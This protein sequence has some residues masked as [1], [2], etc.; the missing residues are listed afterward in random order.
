M[1]LISHTDSHIQRT[2]NRISRILSKLASPINLSL[3]LIYVLVFQAV[4]FPGALA[5]THATQPAV[6]TAPPP[7]SVEAVAVRHAPVVN[8]GRIEGS[9]R[10]LLGENVTINSGGT[11]TGDL[12]V[13]GTPT[14]KLNGSP[15]YGGTIN[16]TG[17]TQPTGYLVT[18]NGGATLGRLVK[19]TD[20]ITLD[21]VAAPP[22]AQ[23]T[24]NVSINSAGQS[25]GDF[26]TLRD[27]TLNANAGLVS[28][29]PGTY[30][31]FTG[32]GG[33]FVFGIAGSTQ[34]TVYNLNQLTLN[35]GSDLRVVGPIVLT[36]GS[37]VTGNGGTFGSAANPTWL[38]LKLAT[39]ILT[40]NS[41]SSLYGIV[42]VPNGTVTLNSG[43][44]Q[45]SL[46]CDRLTINANSQLIGLASVPGTLQSINPTRGMQGQT[47]SVTLTGNNTHWVS[48]QT[49]ASFGGEVSVG[50]A[51]AGS[52]GPVTVLSQTTATADLTI[53][54]TASLSPRTVRVVTPLGGGNSEDISLT[55]A[56]I[57]TAVTPPGAATTNVSTIAGSDSQPGFADGPAAQ[58]RFRNLAGIATSADDTI[59]VAD[60]GNHRIRVVRRQPG[61]GTP[62]WTVQ[63]LAGDGTAG[64]RDGPGAQA[65]FNDPQSVAVDAGGDVYVADTG[66]HRIRR[67]APDGVV[68]TVAGDGVAGYQNGAGAQARFN[69]PRSLALDPQGNVYVADTG[70]SAVRFINSSGQVQTVAG[71][72]TIGMNDSPNAHFNG[73]AGIAVEGTSVFIYL[74]D[75]GNHRIRRLD[76][77]GTVI[78]LTGA[79][80]GFADGQASAA[81]FADPSGLAVDGSGRI[82]VAD[83]TNSLV[84]MVSPDLVINGSP[85]AVA[86]LAGT[87]ERGLLNGAGS[88]SRFNAPRGVA[89]TLSSAIIVSDTG[90]NVLR[91]IGIPPII[92]SF[93]PLSA[94]I[95]ATITIYGENFDGSAPGG[96]IVKFTRAATAGGGQTTAQVSAGSR[97]Q[98]SVVVPP[99]AATGP[100][101]VATTDGTAVSP[102]DFVVNSSLPPAITD[103]HP[104]RGQVGAIVT[105]IGTALQSNTGNTTVTF[106]G[107]DNLRLPALIN[108]VSATEVRTTVPNGAVTG[109]IELT[110]A[111]GVALTSQD[112]IVDE[113]QDFQV[114]AAPASATVLQ[115]G[116]ATFIVYVTS[117][118]T[119]FSQLAQLSAAGLP[120]A[121]TATFRPP[122]ITAGGKTTLSVNLADTNLSPGSYS[123]TINASAHIDGHEVVR[124]VNVNLSVMAA[125]GQ[126][127][128]AGRVLSSEDD[129]IIGA[130]A[131][132]DGHSATTDASGSFLLFGIGDGPNRP[133]MVD[134][135]T[136]NAPNRSYPVIIE[137][138]D[139]IA[140]HANVVPY[141]FYLPAIDTQYEVDVV[142]GQNTAVTNPRV[143]GLA[144]TIPAGANLRNR[145]GS[146]VV[147][148]SI[149]P[150]AIDRTP[151][152]LPSDVRTGMVYTSQPGGALTDVP[153]PVVYPNLTGIDPG[154]E[155]PLYAFNHDTVEWYVYGYGLV[156]QDGRT[157]APETDPNT[158]QPYGLPDFSWH[159]PAAGP[160]GNPG[161]GKGKKGDC[162]ADGR[163]RHMV[164]FSTGMK[165][166]KTTDISFGGARGGLTF[167]RIYTSDLAQSCDFC[168]FGRGTTHNYAI[169]L[170]GGFD[171]GGAGRVIMPEEQTGR[172]FSFVGTD[173]SGA[174]IFTSIGTIDQL[175][176]QVRRLTDNSLE[177]RF[178]AGGVMHFD[179]DGNLTSIVDATG[180]T[181][182]LSYSGGRLTTITDAVGRSIVLSYDGFG[183]V[184]SATDP[185][186][187]VW[188]YSYDGANGL[189]V[190]TAPGN[191]VTRYGYT[192]GGR[193]ASV[194]DPRGNTEK[195]I[196]YDINNRVIAER[197][198]DGSIQRYEYTLSGG[199]V[200]TT[201]ITDE[202]G[203]KITK[204]FNAA[205]YIVGR[206]DG[207]GQTSQVSRNITTNLPES[208]SGPCGC[209]EET[210][211][212][213]SSG[214][215]TSATDRIGQTN[216]FEYDP[217]FHKVT[218]ITD[219]AGRVTRFSY[220]S[221]GNMLSATDPLNQ[222]TTFTYDGYG[223]MTSQTDPLGHTRHME[224]DA[225]GNVTATV[226]ALNERMTF[227]YD[228]NGQM[229]ASVDPLG[230]RSVIEYDELDR[231]KSIT[232]AAGATKSFTYDVNSNLISTTDA[233]NRIEQKEYD[234]KNRVIRSIDSLG[235]VTRTEYD[236]A[237]QVT[238]VVSPQGRRTGYVYNDRGDMIQ[239]IDPLGAIV[240]STYDNRGKLVSITDQR[241]HVTTFLYDELSRNIGTR[242]PLG[243]TVMV[244]YNSNNKVTAATDY[245]GRRTTFTYDAGNRPTQM[246]FA[247][248]IVNYSYDADSRL[249][250]IDDS[251]SGS[252][253]W[254]YDADD[255][256]QTETTAS[257]VVNYTYDATGQVSSMTAADRPPVN[258]G[259]DATGRL[260]TVTQGGGV[261]TYSYDTLSRV[262]SLQRPNGV[263]TTYAYDAVDRLEQIKHTNGLGQ[264]LEDYRYSFNTDG[265]INSIASLASLPL[266]PG[267]R[268]NSVADGANRISQQ[269]QIHSEFD[270]QG[271][272]KSRTD[273]NGTTQYSWDARGRLTQTLLPDGRV[274][275]YGYDPLGR[276][277]SRTASGVTTNFLYD[278]ADIVL[279]R[280]SDGSSIDYLNS[281]GMD[282]KLRQSSAGGAVYFLQDHLG[283]TAA[284]TDENGSVVERQ[285][286]ESFGATTGSVVTRYGYTGR[287]REPES[288]LMYYRARWYDPAQ[289]RFISEDPAGFQGGLNKNTYVSNSPVNNVDPT[290]LYELDVHYYLTYYLATKTGCFSDAEARLIA[291]MDQ[292]TDDNPK[293][294]PGPGKTARQRRV[295]AEYHALHPGAEEGVGSP[296]LWRD[297][298]RGNASLYREVSS[299]GTQA[300]IHDL[301]GLGTYLHY[302]QDTFSHAGFTNSTWGHSPISWLYGDK[303]GTHST[304]KTDYDVP[305]AMRMAGATW[306]ALSQW[307]KEQKCCDVAPWDPSW[308]DQIRRFAE[309]PGGNAIT[310]HTDSIENNNPWYLE[311]KRQ[312]LGMPRR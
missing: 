132:L 72:G 8:G 209:P 189:S 227:E 164:D 148:V 179:S 29:P 229:V 48:G 266:L 84:R 20:P 110:N 77:S 126:T 136:A 197:F 41:N 92:T 188:Q 158:G 108:F 118:Q 34:P 105:L 13:P 58:A 199:M 186:Q 31:N 150:V 235:R 63:T 230:R 303:G 157:I 268:N 184:S 23:G 67:I 203:R 250:R 76:L 125:T 139:I 56:F 272:A 291:G 302:L 135:R 274:V 137:P 49:T 305:K 83:T 271:Q 3:W 187:R 147:R 163:G 286:Y 255:R 54:G 140:G 185:L 254:T 27:L 15:N 217:V 124:A 231:T 53:S 228:V 215:V 55:D 78:T 28:V 246:T 138:A 162:S 292:Y 174:L 239:S 129:P 112:F 298:T 293:T 310:S 195:R 68:T 145:D 169:H 52:L 152:P 38:T 61:G 37:S 221:A 122:Q 21:A 99:D 301:S 166:E 265:E 170:T 238:A 32:N 226:N 223:Q 106:A 17:S 121:V 244:T 1:N 177:Y 116:Q 91:R 242:D 190:V 24:R 270:D 194:I 208:T 69:S 59:F 198:A 306:M 10:Q 196:S 22:A 18:L 153:V 275:A 289:A 120:G 256:K 57:V 249:T 261:F 102:T 104:R 82:I 73:L 115:G 65:R 309:A 123:F 103:F 311:N 294:S 279:D 222:T 257:G 273:P 205:G 204:R 142:P 225:Y 236:L 80:R 307:A 161:G 25:P 30:R 280:G 96:N 178:E 287:E 167:S 183:R 168:P 149:T 201:T 211:Q 262:T 159:F 304:D 74:A 284:L 200:T 267:A 93:A 173:S 278:G 252:I 288:G 210:K 36:M 66:N 241:G 180:N 42:R 258:Y 213:D 50:G 101:S 133:L 308:S 193:L 35:S 165:L 2:R 19:R 206:T 212:F 207:L 5:A 87:G 43:I 14:V 224:Y 12:F 97:T 151:A 155:V 237:D 85:A 232:D 277:A 109:R 160:G 62:T 260:H 154:T 9:A 146:P 214:N 202:L 39:T 100:I 40:L 94:S 98:L 117:T 181:T 171:S 33:S 75:S 263:T 6:P 7:P 95:N 276:R 219:S 141:T 297:A 290:G 283:S 134:G 243:R 182:N 44:L 248:A 247:D 285:Q 299:A 175:G 128:L 16:G 47:L 88:V 312:I 253:A 113:T 86:T 144:M 45:G 218:R 143:T 111:G 4:T 282:D 300:L 130:T 131:S 216:A 281:Q 176:D 172:L 245:L 64:Y 114:T 240:K 269:G 192:I 191:D 119:T 89:V 51:A 251:Q 11:I 107:P 156:S 60:A 90:N 296:A 79:E 70:N 264:I 233:L 127:T 295:N 46:Q 81:R 71:D 26:A 259:Y 220:D 234:V